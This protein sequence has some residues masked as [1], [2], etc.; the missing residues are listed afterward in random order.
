M[1]VP[2]SAGGTVFRR[3]FVIDAV[4]LQLAVDGALRDIVCGGEVDDIEASLEGRFE[5]RCRRIGV[6]RE[7]IQVECGDEVGLALVH[8]GL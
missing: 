5:I 2:E 3:R 6:R 8:R 7:L 4:A 1:G